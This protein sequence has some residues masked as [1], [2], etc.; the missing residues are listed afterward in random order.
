VRQSPAIGCGRIS[1]GGEKHVDELHFDGDP[2]TD[3]TRRR[4]ER[5]MKGEPR[6]KWKWVAA[7][8]AGGTALLFWQMRR[9]STKLPIANAQPPK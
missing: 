4:L 7:F 6:S 3:S 9:R 1:N 8:A 5:V 2:E